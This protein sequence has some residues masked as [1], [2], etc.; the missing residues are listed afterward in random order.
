[1]NPFEGFMCVFACVRDSEPQPAKGQDEAVYFSLLLVFKV[2][3][4]S[5][6]RMM[7]CVILCYLHCQT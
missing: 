4:S 2:L 7:H 1:M 3:N 6:N 5:S